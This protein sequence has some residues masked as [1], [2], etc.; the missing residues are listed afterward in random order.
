MVRAQRLHRQGQGE[1]GV[2]A[3][4][5][6][7]HHIG[8]A[9]AAGV[10]AQAQHDLAAVELAARQAVAGHGGR[11]I[12][13]VAACQPEPALRKPQHAQFGLEAAGLED[14][15]AIGLHGERGPVVHQLVVP[16]HMVDVQQRQAVA[17]GG[18]AQHVVALAALADVGRAGVDGHHQVG[19]G[20]AQPLEG[21]GHVALAAVVPAVF[22]DQKAHAHAPDG[23]QAHGIGAGIEV[24]A[25]VEH[26]V[27]GQQLLGAGQQ[28]VATPDDVQ[29]VVQAVARPGVAHRQ[30]H[31]PVQ[32]GHLAR[33]QQQRV[34]RGLGALQK[35]GVGQQ[36]AGVVA[37]EGQFRKHD[38]I[39]LLLPG[40]A[41]GGGHLAHV[42]VQVA[43]GEVEL[44]HCDIEHGKTPGVAFSLRGR[45]RRPRRAWRPR[46]GV[47][48][49]TPGAGR[50]ERWC[51]R[52]GFCRGCR[53]A[54]PRAGRC[55]G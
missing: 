25:L 53:T 13:F 48:R 50:P 35:G 49:E 17:A 32:A 40:P 14:H 27:G 4:R 15:A 6:A 45:G 7:H 22:A 44:G 38:H 8:K 34:E 55:S 10:V 21:V 36:V 11:G 3:A 37:G 1:R 12:A 46:P 18:L 20:I 31:H 42:A 51:R 52:T 41:G 23:Q 29:R 9:A 39:G 33:G 16:A 54:W 30:A 26:V 24:A 19:R 47:P 2:D 5:A 28:D 43:H